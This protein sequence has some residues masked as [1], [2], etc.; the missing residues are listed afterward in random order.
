MD[1]MPVGLPTKMKC[2]V[3]ETY[4]EGALALYEVLTKNS[5]RASVKVLRKQT[6]QNNLL[7]SSA[8]AN[9]HTGI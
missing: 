8:A 5:F 6:R 2:F 7:P 3:A 9:M 4:F 1:V